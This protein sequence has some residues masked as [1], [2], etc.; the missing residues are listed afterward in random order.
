MR[1]GDGRCKMDTYLFM[2]AT[3]GAK[4]FC[5]SSCAIVAVKSSI[6]YEVV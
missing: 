3:K 5:L 6:Y 1:D 4:A 2:S